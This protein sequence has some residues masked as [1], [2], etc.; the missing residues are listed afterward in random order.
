MDVKSIS[1]WL[2]S[3]TGISTSI[4]GVSTLRRAVAIRLEAQSLTDTQVYLALLLNSEE[5]Q[6]ALVDLLVVPETWFFRDRQPF[7]HLQAHVNQRLHEISSQTPLRLLSAPCS[8]GEEPYSMAMTLLDLGIPANHFNIDAVDICKPSIRKARKAVYTN[9]SFRGVTTSERQR[10]FRTTAEGFVLDPAIASTVRFYRSN[11]MRCLEGFGGSYDVVFC[12]N[13]LIYLEDQAGTY[14]LETIAGLLKPGG[15]L[16]VGAAEMGKVPAALFQPLRQSFV[17]GFER[18]SSSGCEAPSPAPAKPKPAA[19]LPIS[20]RS[21][22]PPATTA[23]RRLR[24][25]PMQSKRS[26]TETLNSFPAIL[27][28]GFADGP[29]AELE[30]CRRRLQLEPTS[31]R[32]YLRMAEILLQLEQKQEAF[33]CLQKCLYL[34]TKSQEALGKLI[35]LSRELDQ[36]E[37]SQRYEDRLARLKTWPPS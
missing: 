22:P 16:V 11:L 27:A 7:V 24:P 34:Q 6:D 31:D 15:L 28:P 30:R 20:S 2:S 19:T 36:L 17:F 8:S 25:P 5:E 32:T 21:Q 18:R 35:S 13:L 14:L 3:H 1:G 29:A 26:G 9:H 10:H 37:Q 23:P 12:R 4:I 33:D